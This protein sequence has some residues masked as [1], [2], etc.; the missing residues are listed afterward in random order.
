M[1]TS[2]TKTGILLTSILFLAGCALDTM[3]AEEDSEMGGEV[4]EGIIN[5]STPLGSLDRPYESFFVIV[6]GR[7]S[8]TLLGSN[9]QYAN[10]VL[11]ARHCLDST[12]DQVSVKRG[13]E[14]RTSKRVIFAPNNNGDYIDAALIEL[15]GPSWRV[16]G[17]VY[18]T[19]QDGQE[20]IGVPVRCY[21][22]GH[23]KRASD[24]TYSGFG[25]LRWGDFT[26]KDHKG[27][28]TYYQLQ[29]PNGKAQLLA[30][31]DSG[32]SC[33]HSASA[34]HFDI[35]ITGVHKAGNASNYNVQTGAKWMSSWVRSYVPRP[36]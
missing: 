19:G 11:T 21:G 28:R 20:L 5:G 29:V 1:S 34:A 2:S 31:G 10:W 14:V 6:D 8:G 16:P 18:F 22:Y 30:P 17:G 26:I 13:G 23:N 7:C 36:E 32:S 15:N 33:F 3:P 27:S 9:R 4:A 24:G 35:T 12:S 25:T